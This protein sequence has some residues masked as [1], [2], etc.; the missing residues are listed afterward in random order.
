MKQLTFNSCRAD[1]RRKG[2]T[3]KRE[4]EKE[5]LQKTPTVGEPSDQHLNVTSR[6]MGL[7][8]TSATAT[9][10]AATSPAAAT[11]I[12][13]IFRSADYCVRA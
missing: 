7:Q 5:K 2:Q 3:V 9:T 1:V 11:T 8:N 10:A 13:I 12:G 4:R 6:K